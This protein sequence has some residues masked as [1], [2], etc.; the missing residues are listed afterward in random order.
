MNHRQPSRP[1]SRDGADRRPHGAQR[2]TIA[3]Q[4]WKSFAHLDRF[5]RDPARAHRPAWAAF[6]RA[7]A[8]NGAVGIWH[9]QRCGNCSF[10]KRWDGRHGDLSVRTGD[11]EC[12]YN[13][14]PLFGLARATRAVP[15]QGR[16]Q[17]A[18]GRMTGLS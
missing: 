18:R 5:A 9:T 11:Y 12:I 15:A 8:S 1:R 2:A 6:N 14:M 13:N 7:V 3:L 4:Y 17:A 10:G 16:R